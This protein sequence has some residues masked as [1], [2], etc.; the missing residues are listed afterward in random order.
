MSFRR[1][2]PA[3]SSAYPSPRPGGTRE[4]PA[5]S[6]PVVTTDDAT[7]S[8]P[9][10]SASLGR[11]ACRPNRCRPERCFHAISRRADLLVLPNDYESPTRIGEKS[12]IP[13]VAP[14]VAL[15]LRQPVVQ[16][17]LRQRR[18]DWTPMP[19]APSALDRNA[20]GG[21]HDVGTTAEPGH[22]GHMLSKAE[23]PAMQFASQGS[24]R[25]GVRRPISAHHRPD[26]GR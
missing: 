19:K 26:R 17:G 22:N 8:H 23:S 20:C 3:R 15:E 11:W 13:L 12:L 10:R 9:H 1:L 6:T 2:S 5:P 21:K 24:L 7:R 25:L 4:R 16:V 14:Y 18:V